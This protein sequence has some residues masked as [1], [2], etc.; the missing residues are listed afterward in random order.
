MHSE[1]KIFEPSADYLTNYVNSGDERISVV[2]CGS[3]RYLCQREEVIHRAE[4]IKC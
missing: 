2:L 1:E 3:G 4:M